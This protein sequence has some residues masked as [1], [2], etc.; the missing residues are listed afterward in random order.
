MKV[1]R[2]FDYKDNTFKVVQ[3][4]TGNL[5]GYLLNF[6]T[7]EFQITNSLLSKVLRSGLGDDITEISEEEFVELTEE[8]RAFHLRGDG[9]IFAIYETIDNWFDQRDSL[10][11]A[12]W[13]NKRDFISELRRRTFHLW[14]EEFAHREAGIPPS[15]TYES[16]TGPAAVERYAYDDTTPDRNFP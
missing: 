7:G 14:E 1:P 4:S 16:T 6:Y 5:R 8:T 10:S 13:R 3:T 11:E 9:P 15:F 12:E 2:Y